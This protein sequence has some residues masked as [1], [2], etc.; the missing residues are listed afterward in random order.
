MWTRAVPFPDGSDRCQN[1]QGLVSFVQNVHLG[2]LWYL[3]WEF[4]VCWG[5]LW[6]SFVRNE[7]MNEMCWVLSVRPSVLDG[8]MCPPAA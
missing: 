5:A 7:R 8:W 1:T 2:C 6:A 3:V 4:D